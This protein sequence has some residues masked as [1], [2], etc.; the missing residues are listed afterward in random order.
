MFKWYSVLFTEELVYSTQ[1]VCLHHESSTNYEN[2]YI[3]QV[4][5]II[6]VM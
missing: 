2:V 4:S 6:V 5:P 1:F 3:L